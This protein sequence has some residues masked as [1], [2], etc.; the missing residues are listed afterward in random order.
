MGL[1]FVRHT[2]PLVEE[3]LCYGR[4]DLDVCASFEVEAQAVISKLSQPHILISS[5][6]LRCRKLAKRIG[7]VFSLP[8]NIDPR[9]IEIDFGKWEGKLWNNI[10]HSDLDIWAN[11]FMHARPHGG[12]SVAM[13]RDRVQ[14]VIAEYQSIN[15][16]HIIV[17][18]AGVMKAA[19]ST[20]DRPDDFSTS[21]DFGG[22]ISIPY[23]HNFGK[24]DDR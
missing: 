10:P 20:G 6:L 13:L 18:H 19:L 14:E 12:E 1:S 24:H 2:R 4:T 21:I 16:T 8:V 11:D 22:V 5:P 23:T 9:L 3:G 15:R 17:T 7:N